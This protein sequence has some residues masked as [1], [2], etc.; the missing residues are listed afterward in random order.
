MGR[1]V[2]SDDPGSQ[3]LLQVMGVLFTVQKAESHPGTGHVP[4]DGFY[5]LTD[6]YLIK[7]VVSVAHI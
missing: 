4:V 7:S 5:A 2:A 6:F 3:C 1:F